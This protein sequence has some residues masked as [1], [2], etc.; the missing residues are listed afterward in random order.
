M[1]VLQIGADRSRRG[2]LHMGSPAFKRQEA[3]AKRFG[4]LDVIGFSLIGDGVQDIDSGTL[5]IHPTNSASRLLYGWDALRI[6]Q[7]LPR[8]DVVSAQDPFEA[9]LAAN[10]IARRLKIPL[11]IQ[12]HTDFLAPEYARH[13]LLNRL[14]VLMA[15]YI[16]RRAKRIRVVSERIKKSIQERYQLSVPITVLPIFADL[17]RIRAAGDPVIT[18]RFKMF[19]MRLLLVSRLEPEKDACL[20]LRAFAASA[21]QDACLIIVGRGSERPLLERLARE[22]S[23]SERVFF[24]GERD[25]APYYSAADLVL[26][27]SHYEGYGL[28]IIEA[29]AAGKPVLST[30]VGIARE[31]GAIVT[32][33][34]AFADSLEKWFVDGPRQAELKNYPYASFDDYVA[35]YCAD[36][37]SIEEVA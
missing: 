7:E 19:R 36:I 13:S 29:L 18:S 32:S 6:A 26:V 17:E 15:G 14:R 33:G 10:R 21:P 25:A 3:Y 16:L 20:A 31:A 35:R 9:G 37:A 4:E 27:T 22:L 5:H 34:V 23:V 30:D 24:E 11:H 28:V 12:V 2:I 1:R 8:F